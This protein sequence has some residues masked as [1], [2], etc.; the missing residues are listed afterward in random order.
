[1]NFNLNVEIPNDNDL[2][3]L[4][5]PIVDSDLRNHKI[6]DL[7]LDLNNDELWDKISSELEKF[8]I[9]LRKSDF[10][11]GFRVIN[12]IICFMI[13]AYR[14]ENKSNDFNW[15]RYF[16][17]Q[18]KQKILPK[19]HQYKRSIGETLD[20]LFKLCLKDDVNLED[21]EKLSKDNTKYYH[22]ALKLQK[23]IKILS[24]Q[25]YVSFID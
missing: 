13:V 23:M 22:S 16:D 6:E 25:K 8:I 21:I 11:F 2:E 17:A 19:L 10:D 14:Y 12:E 7:K 4:E 18:I 9:P 1:M 15:E 5:N 24:N 3:Y 20:D